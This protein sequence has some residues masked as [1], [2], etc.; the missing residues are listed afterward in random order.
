MLFIPNIHSYQFFGRNPR[1]LDILETTDCSCKNYDVQFKLIQIATEEN[2][3]Y[4]ALSANRKDADLFDKAK[5]KYKTFAQ[6]FYAE[7]VI[8]TI[9]IGSRSAVYNSLEELLVTGNAQNPS[10]V[11]ATRTAEVTII[12]T[13]PNFVITECEID[14]TGTEIV[15]VDGLWTV[16]ARPVIK[17]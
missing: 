12:I 10:N 6:R 1:A 3:R 17:D 13:T 15:R 2:Y 16:Y 9:N 11:E 5:T 14:Y 8:S 7:D 4:N